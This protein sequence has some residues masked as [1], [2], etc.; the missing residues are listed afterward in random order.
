MKSV[1][2]LICCLVMLG[3][4]I[5]T[6]IPAMAPSPGKEVARGGVREND[7]PAVIT[8]PTSEGPLA[9]RPSDEPV[10]VSIHA[11]MVE[12]QVTSPR[13]QVIVTDFEKQFES[14]VAA[15]NS[16]T[17]KNPG[18]FPAHETM[19]NFVEAYRGEG[20]AKFFEEPPR[21]VE[22]GQTEAWGKIIS[23]SATPNVESSGRVLLLL[24]AAAD[25]SHIQSPTYVQ[26]GR[27]MS[28]GGNQQLN[29]VTKPLFPILNRIPSVGPWLTVPVTRTTGRLRIFLVTATIIPSSSDGRT[30]PQ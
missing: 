10:K 27:I 21:I 15:I 26:S 25:G 20:V 12:F 14:T 8:E 30:G 4:I 28:L 22:A 19:A 5:G 9:S 11:S 24:S 1:A 7:S 3:L 2:V 17:E 29:T 23:I 13:A 18:A 16:A 6:M